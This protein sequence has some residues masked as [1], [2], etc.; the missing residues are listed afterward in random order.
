M[1]ILNRNVVHIYQTYTS[2]K[3]Q[4][5]YFRNNIHTNPNIT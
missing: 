1:C 4:T 2:L 5:Y 3:K